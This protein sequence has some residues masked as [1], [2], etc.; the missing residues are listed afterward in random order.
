[1]SNRMPPSFPQPFA[2]TGSSY[3]TRDWA[4]TSEQRSR[5]PAQAS[6]YPPDSTSLG[7]SFDTSSWSQP[8]Y[9][10]QSHESTPHLMPILNPPQQH[11]SPYLAPHIHTH[12]LIQ[13]PISTHPTFPMPQVQDTRVPGSTISSY[14][15]PPPMQT[16]RAPGYL[17]NNQVTPGHYSTYSLQVPIMSHSPLQQHGSGAFGVTHIAPLAQRNQDDSD[18]EEYQVDQVSPATHDGNVRAKGPPS[19][20]AAGVSDTNAGEV[21]P[22]ARD[23]VQMQSVIASR[24]KFRVA[25]LKIPELRS[26]YLFLIKVPKYF[27]SITGSD[28]H[29]AAL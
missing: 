11:P 4:G 14:P 28:G 13:G 16:T 18:D 2:P 26:C 8:P 6:T 7:T 9:P 15:P 3:P 17:N 23:F 5:D 21:I 29:G 24:P 20:G 10:V 27:L 1:M 22:R 25:Q 19:Y 12:Q